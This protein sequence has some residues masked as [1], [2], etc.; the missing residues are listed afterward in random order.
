MKKTQKSSPLTTTDRNIILID[1]ENANGGPIKTLEQAR[2]CHRM[3]TARLG[4][5]FGDQVVLACNGHPDSVL[6]LHLAWG[7]SAR[8]VL[9]YGKDGADKA[10]LEVMKENLAARFSRAVLVS[11]D[12]IF[13]EPVAAL[14]GQ[15]LPTDVVAHPAGLSSAL[16]LAATT[17]SPIAPSYPSTPWK[18]A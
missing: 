7:R 14:A 16:R 12:G 9:G 15:G 2:W 10:L 13:A 1:I 3:I 6:S 18:A 11:G 8:I 5:A 17:V 4:I